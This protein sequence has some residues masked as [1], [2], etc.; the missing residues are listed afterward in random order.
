M[1]CSFRTLALKYH[2]AKDPTPEAAIEYCRVCEA[3]EV[4]SNRAIINA[5]MSS[6]H[7]EVC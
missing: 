1:M 6:G 5:H 4:L 2:P 3:Y 7:P